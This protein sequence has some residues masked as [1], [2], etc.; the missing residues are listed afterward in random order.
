[1]FKP[2][3]SGLP[4]TCPQPPENEARE[5][6]CDCKTVNCKRG[7]WEAWSA[8]CGLATRKRSITTEQVWKK[9]SLLVFFGVK[10]YNQFKDTENVVLSLLIWPNSL[11]F[12]F[13]KKI[14]KK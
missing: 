4:Q 11:I 13:S 6:K 3:C 14:I 9:T 8:T 12:Y 10:R 7:E 2:D 1:M 5:I